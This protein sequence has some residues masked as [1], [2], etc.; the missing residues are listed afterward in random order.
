MKRIISII[1]T[2]CIFISTS[3][4]PFAYTMSDIN[5]TLPED[6]AIS[7]QN[8]DAEHEDESNDNK[9]NVQQNIEEENKSVD[10]EIPQENLQ[11]QNIEDNFSEELNSNENLEAVTEEEDDFPIVEL[12]EEEIDALSKEEYALWKEGIMQKKLEENTSDFQSSDEEIPLLRTQ[13]RNHQSDRIRNSY[14]EAAFLNGCFTMGTT[15]G[16]PELLSDDNKKLL[17]GH[18]EPWSSYTTIKIGQKEKAFSAYETVISNSDENVSREMMEGVEIK[19][20]LS[21]YKNPNTGKEDMIEI[22]Y[23]LTNLSSETKEVGARIMLDTQL[24]D[25]DGAPFRIDGVGECTSE[26]EFIGDKIPQSWQAFDSLKNPNVISSGIFYFDEYQRPDKVQFAYWRTINNVLWDYS[27]VNGRALTHDSAV[28]MYYNPEELAPNESRTIVTYYGL[29]KFTVEDLRPPLSVAVIAPNSLKLNPSKDKYVGNPV[30]ITAYI[31]NIG[32]W[33]AS[34]V[35]AQI[36]LPPEIVLTKASDEKIEFGE[37]ESRERVQF[38]WK[39]YVNEQMEEKNLEC[40][41]VVTSSNTEGKTLSFQ[42][43]VPK[44]VK[45]YGKKAIIFLHG[46][47]GSEIYASED[48]NSEDY[49]E[50]KVDS[51]DYEK[52]KY[53]KGHQFWAPKTTELYPKQELFFHEQ[54]IQTE[55]LM[56]SLDERGRTLVPTEADNRKYHKHWYGAKNTYGKIV[57]ALKDTFGREYNHGEDIHFFAYDWRLSIRD[58]AQKLQDFIDEK[59]YEEV[60][61]VAHSMGG[62]VSSVYLSNSQENRKKVDKLITIGTPYLGAPKGLYV[63]GTG[64][65]FKAKKPN[66]LEG[67]GTAFLLN[68]VLKIIAPNMISGYELL[69]TRNYFKLNNT[70]YLWKV[71]KLVEDTIYPHTHQ[72]L[73]RKKKIKTYDA[74]NQIIDSVW[75]KGRYFVTRAEETQKKLFHN[76]KHITD[77]V[78]SYYIMGYGVNT[79]QEVAVNLDQYNRHV[80]TENLKSDLQGD[81]TVPLISANIGGIMNLDKTFYVKSEHAELVSNEDVLGLVKD[82]IIN[83][84]DAKPNSNIRRSLEGYK[85]SHDSKKVR[86]ACPVNVKI[87]RDSDI[88]ASFH[89][90]E[91]SENI[92]NRDLATCY[93]LGE[94]NRIKIAYLSSDDLHEIEL[95]GY[96]N[97]TME[98]SMEELGEDNEPIRTL[99]FENIPITDKTKIYTNTDMTHLVLKIDKDSDGVIDEVK[100]PSFDSDMKYHLEIQSSAGGHITKGVSGKYAKYETIEIAAQAEENYRFTGWTSSDKGWFEDAKKEQTDF[101]MSDNPNVLVA[102]FEKIISDSGVNDENIYYDT[103][104]SNDVVT[105]KTQNKTFETKI[106]DG[107]NIHSD[108]KKRNPF[109]DVKE[110]NRY[111]NDI[112]YVY[113]NNIMIG[114]N[115]EPRLFSPEHTLNRAMLVVILYRLSGSLKV[116]NITIPF[117]DIQ[118]NIWYESAIKW[119]YANK[120]IEGYSKTVFAPEDEITKQ[121]FIVIL[122]RYLN[123]RNISLKA[124]REK[125]VFTDETMISHY[126]SDAIKEFYEANLIEM[127]DEKKIHPKQYMSREKIA[128]ILHVFSEYI[129][130]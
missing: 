111:F 70:N 117:K 23:D 60:I 39:A 43:V 81:G 96:D 38:T 6:D 22:R 78:D 65:M 57:N 71:D 66:D 100:T 45:K 67:H 40:K 105:K 126:A 13:I 107:G 58:A 63:L 118:K 8:K 7:N 16:N 42:I 102:N 116:E 3:I 4:F 15:G 68:G 32:A 122:S 89:D 59:G 11:D 91:F 31:E 44:S 95:S 86:I 88:A 27:I 120:I 110:N 129:K 1:L 5:S 127:D 64:N 109:T 34:D 18:P 26:L 61:L 80:S 14:L 20:S 92:E 28:A 24:G 77:F 50:G 72:T 69:P 108:K 124:N 128:G 2:M 94:D 25:N 82:I 46:I 103:S 51:F 53:D 29:N 121:D 41:V 21:F 115:A 48:V 12:S 9:E 79:I 73:I 62:L 17:F 30:N 84:K 52:V 123:Y 112:L 19:Q 87:T 119:A 101:Y 114:T 85:F 83:G 10:I 54:T 93:R 125:T 55:T 47:I 74:T 98:F 56:L 90:T 35:V 33:Y 37:L 75:T 113:E 49:L 99:A 76:K 36:K 104:V 130:K 106:E 97:G